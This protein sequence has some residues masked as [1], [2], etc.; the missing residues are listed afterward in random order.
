MIIFLKKMIKKMINKMI[1]MKNNWINIQNNLNKYKFKIKMISMNKF[2]ILI[3]QKLIN[4]I[5]HKIL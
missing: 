4:L 2:K 1:I 5:H 3:L